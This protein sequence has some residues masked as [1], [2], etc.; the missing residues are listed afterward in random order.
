MI[1]PATIFLLITGI[2]LVGFFSHALYLNK[3]VYGDGIYYYSWLRSIVVDGDVH[4][5]NDFQSFG[6]AQ[7]PAPGG[8]WGNIY[9]VG[10]AIFWFPAFLM[11]HTIVGGS[12]FEFPYQVAVGISSVFFAVIGLLLLFRLLSQF[13]T[14]TIALLTVLTIAFTTNLWFYGSIDTV[15]SHA[16]SFFVATLFL[17]LLFAKKKNFFLLGICVGLLGLIRIQDAIF[18]I[19]LLP[20]LNR[21][22]IIPIALGSFLMFLPQLAAW[23]ALYNKFWVSPYLDRGYGFNFFTPHIFDVLFSLNNGLLLW[24][25]IVGLSFV[26][27]LFISEIGKINKL[28]FI[29]LIITQLVLIASWTTWWQGASFSGRM[30]ISVLPIFSFGLA[31]V[32]LWL[33]T[34]HWP[35]I[36]YLLCIIIPLSVINALLIVS[37][38]LK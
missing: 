26:G 32:F 36:Y 38:L 1:R 37:F 19:L 15:N 28:L 20:F 29:A 5:A 23:Q 34:Y 8:R 22:T 9:A 18:G 25:P 6:A 16:L 31:R 33:K 27:L 3:T 14:E 17:T 12:G 4:F 35:T 13:F 24:T 30:F 7:L 21:K 10:P 2:Y 11:V